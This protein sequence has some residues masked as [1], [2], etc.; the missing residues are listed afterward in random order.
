MTK[1]IRESVTDWML[2][3]CLNYHHPSI[4]HS[5][6]DFRVWSFV[7][8]QMGPMVAT[9]DHYCSCSGLIKCF[10]SSSMIDSYDL[11]FFKLWLYV[12]ALTCSC[13]HAILSLACVEERWVEETL[14]IFLVCCW[15]TAPSSNVMEQRQI[16][17]AIIVA[18]SPYF[19]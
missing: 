3:A 6:H 8:E 18:T 17:A 2:N 11:L 19:N 13:A 10:S 5:Q 15:S 16:C 4:N 1:V 14:P 7:S 12:A 9:S